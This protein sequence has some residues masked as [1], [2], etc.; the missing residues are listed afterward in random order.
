MELEQKEM[1][2]FLG[3]SPAMLVKHGRAGCPSA[4][5]G[6]RRIYDPAAVVGWL[7][8]RAGQRAG[9]NEART[10]LLRAQA[11]LKEIELARVKG[12]LVP[13][14]EV[15]STWGAIVLKVRSRI[16][17]LIPHGPELAGLAPAEAQA[18]LK[19]LVYA[20]LAELAGG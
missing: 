11:E 17:Q 3:I 19:S 18:R 8:R 5:R 4:R 12:L 14:G 13:V 2:E 20:A 15:E 16:L 1:A 7:V 10:R 6:R 9:L